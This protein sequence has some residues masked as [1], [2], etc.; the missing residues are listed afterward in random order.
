M[1]VR[2][3]CVTLLEEALHHLRLVG[4]HHG[5]G[6]YMLLQIGQRLC[7][8][9]PVFFKRGFSSRSKSFKSAFILR[10]FGLDFGRLAAVL[11]FMRVDNECRATLEQIV[12]FRRAG[13][14]IGR[15]GGGRP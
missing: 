6:V 10:G 11:Q 1:H 7:P 15:K 14:E 2:I 12:G 4:E 13:L 8:G 3:T 9:A 5:H